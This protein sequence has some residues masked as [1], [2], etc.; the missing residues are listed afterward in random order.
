MFEPSKYQVAIYNHIQDV[1]NGAGKRHA[2]ID[3]LA[4]SGKSTTAK[5][6]LQFIPRDQKILFTAFNKLIADALAPEVAR[7]HPQ[8]KAQTLHS[9]GYEILRNYFRGLKVN[10][11]KI[12]DILQAVHFDMND[13]EQKNMYFR[14][15]G[16]IK[17]IVSLLKATSVSMGKTSTEE[18]EGIIDTY[19][20]EI[21]GAKERVIEIVKATYEYSLQTIQTVLEIDYDDMI[22]G[23]AFFNLKPKQYEWVIVDEFQ[24]FNLAQ[25]NLIYGAGKDGTIITFGDPNQ[26]I[27]GFTGAHNGIMDMFRE[28]MKAETLPL[29]V[30][31]R[32]PKKVLAL[33]REIVPEIEDAPNAIEGNVETWNADKFEHTMPERA[34]NN[35]GPIVLCRFTAPLVSWCLKMIRNEVKAT[36]KGRDIGENLIALVDKINLIGG[37]DFTWKATTYKATELERLS[38]FGKEDQIEQFNDKMDT[39][40]ALISGVEGKE[41]VTVANIRKKIESIFSADNQQHHDG[42]LFSTVHKAKGLEFKDV[43]ILRPKKKAKTTTPAQA[44]EERRIEYVA[45]TRS[46]ENL[47]FITL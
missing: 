43:Y 16:P 17:R 29:S 5:A 34:K 7:L 12:D 47:T 11:Y 23:P 41:P 22:A 13:R 40:F 20:I 8:A 6:L 39:I 15:K 27:Y 44:S 4:G 32:C 9:F 10:A 33:A 42:I 19:G 21:P 37:V 2:R 36:V 28:G 46:Q 25:L 24:D 45:L 35:P 18:I 3:A 1:T 31:Y 30:C 14:F 38:R 26:A